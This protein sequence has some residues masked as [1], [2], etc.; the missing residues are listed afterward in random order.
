MPLAWGDAQAEPH[1]NNPALGRN[2]RSYVP[3]HLRGGGGPDLG[4]P[5]GNY[6]GASPPGPVPGQFIPQGGPA[7]AW[8]GR[9]GAQNWGGPGGGGGG[10]GGDY[11]RGGGGGGWGGPPGGGGYGGGGYGYGPRNGGGGGGGWGGGGGR[12]SNPFAAQEQED[13]AAAA[14]EAPTDAFSGENTGINFEAYEDIPVETSGENCPPP[15]TTFA[16]A[17]LGEKVM[18]NVV[19]CKYT[20]PTPVQKHAIPISMGGRDLMAC[21]QTGS[22]KTAA[23]CFPIIAGILKQGPPANRPRGGRKAFPLALILSPT[24]ELTSQVS[25]QTTI[26]PLEIVVWFN[27][28][29]HCAV[30]RHSRLWLPQRPVAPCRPIIAVFQ[31]PSRSMPKH[32]SFRTR[33]ACALLWCMGGR[34]CFSRYSSCSTVA[35]DVDRLRVTSSEVLAQSIS[36]SCL[37]T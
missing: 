17:D 30:H 7:G 8:A 19:R 29:L 24:R 4:P 21:A 27:T 33:L 28:H 3:P 5:L 11:R 1:E 35:I 18:M 22:G 15:I 32:K 12:E 36:I 10:G 16:D 20:K 37:C 2:A 31:F 26:A 25:H 34:Q 6:P 9:G 14:V 23:F 13:L